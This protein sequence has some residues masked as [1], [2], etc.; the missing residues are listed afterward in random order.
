[1]AARLC[2]FCAG[3]LTAGPRECPTCRR[4]QPEITALTTQPA[5]PEEE[6]EEKARLAPPPELARAAG[7]VYNRLPDSLFRNAFLGG[8]G[9][10]AICGTLSLLIGRLEGLLLL[11][12]SPLVGLLAAVAVL[13]VATF[14]SGLYE[15]LAGPSPVRAAGGEARRMLP[16]P[17]PQPSEERI[18]PAG[19][20]SL[21]TAR[22]AELTADADAPPR[23]APAPAVVPEAPRFSPFVPVM[24]LVLGAAFGL[25]FAFR[26]GPGWAAGWAA[27]F[28]L[29]VGFVLGALAVRWARR[30]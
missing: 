23:E 13:T 24:L 28:G 5:E 11:L 30:R 22:P 3:Y 27:C 10:A 9:L 21:V 7:E 18:Q 20:P 4:A 29:P 17:G 6:E 25:P 15:A 8:L 12:G 19:P 26:A 14:L 1:M 16:A 2:A